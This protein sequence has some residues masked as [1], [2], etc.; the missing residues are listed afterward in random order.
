MKEWNIL[1]SIYFENCCTISQVV[2]ATSYMRFKKFIFGNIYFTF[3]LTLN[4][5]LRYKIHIWVYRYL[6]CQTNRSDIRYTEET[7]G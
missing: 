5:N 2:K 7:Y 3:D 4:I 1:I 6:K